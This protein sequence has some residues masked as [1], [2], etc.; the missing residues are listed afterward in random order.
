VVLGHWVLPPKLI[1]G[2]D[3]STAL[4]R[5]RCNRAAHIVETMVGG[6][7]GLHREPPHPV[8]HALDLSKIGGEIIRVSDGLQ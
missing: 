3:I 4:D 1:K 2:D 7:R 6:L 8:E 5:I